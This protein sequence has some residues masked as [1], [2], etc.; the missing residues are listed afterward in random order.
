[1]VENVENM[2]LQL[3]FEAVPSAEV[4]ALLKQNGFR[5]APSS[6]AW[7]RQL[8]DN[9]RRALSAL[10]PKLEELLKGG[11]TMS[12][13]FW[14]VF[15]LLCIVAA[16]RLLRWSATF[17][18]RAPKKRNRPSFPVCRGRAPPPPPPAAGF[19]LDARRLMRYD[20]DRT[21]LS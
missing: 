11:I 12:A 17:P 13:C 7:Q 8:T 19:I 3:L 18:F 15:P 4:R 9:A 10:R 5:Y 2:R 20:T 21:S 1:M 6:H 14:I 16:Y